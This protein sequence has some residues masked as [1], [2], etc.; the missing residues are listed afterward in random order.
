MSPGSYWLQAL[1][2]RLL[3]V[4]LWTGRLIVIFDFA[5]QCAL[6]FWLAAQLASN[7]QRRNDRTDLRR[8]SRSPTRR[9]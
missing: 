6:V 4:S 7:G 1:V 8:I 3:G 9:F 2:F 5:L